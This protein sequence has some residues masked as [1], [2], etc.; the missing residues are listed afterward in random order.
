MANIHQGRGW[1]VS[2][3]SCPAIRYTPLFAIQPNTL[4]LRRSRW[5]AIVVDK[6]LNAI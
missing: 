2:V 5:G 6:R 4:Y 3:T 1:R